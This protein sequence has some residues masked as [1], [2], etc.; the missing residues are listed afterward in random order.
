MLGFITN[1][2]GRIKDLMQLVGFIDLVYCP[3]KCYIVA[4]ASKDFKRRD[5][6]NGCSV[7]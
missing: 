5:I 3:K 4:H 6:A 1:V 2:V 7:P